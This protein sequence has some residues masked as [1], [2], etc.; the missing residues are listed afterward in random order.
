[1]DKKTDPAVQA[2]EL[3]SQARGQVDDGSYTH[4]FKRPFS[5]QGAVME[6]LTFDWDALTGADYLAVEGEMLRQGKTLVTPEFTGEF[7]CGMAARA[8]TQ[9]DADGFRMVSAEA[10]KALP[11]REFKAICQS[12]RSFLLRGVL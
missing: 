7:L 6:Q 8:C 5:Y 3:E 2:A 12:A 1:M 11:L 10:L 4:V 9:R